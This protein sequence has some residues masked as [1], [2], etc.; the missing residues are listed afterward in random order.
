MIEQANI[1]RK[2][3]GSVLILLAG[4]ALLAGCGGAKDASSADPPRSTSVPKEI[5]RGK[6]PQPAGDIASVH[7]AAIAKQDTEVC[8]QAVRSAPSL[9]AAAKA[10]IAALCFRINFVREDNE[11]TMRAICQ[12]VAN[13]SSLSSDVA[14]KRTVSACYA[15]GFKQQ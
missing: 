11:K 8:E 7:N 6:R 5:N 13:A 12:E 14:R 10:E 9:A 2:L 1:R 4:G 15:A 3:W